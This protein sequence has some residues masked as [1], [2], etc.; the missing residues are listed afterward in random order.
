MPKQTSKLVS[1]CSDLVKTI[2]VQHLFLLMHA[3]L[4]LTNRMIMATTI[5]SLATINCSIPV[6]AGRENC[7][8][9]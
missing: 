8:D 2:K 5:K 7:C 9:F 6:K 3:D 1:L 4:I